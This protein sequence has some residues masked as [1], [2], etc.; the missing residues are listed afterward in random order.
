MQIFEDGLSREN[1]ASFWNQ[2]NTLGNQLVSGQLHQV[3]GG[4]VGRVET[5]FA[6]GLRQHAGQRFKGA[7]FASAVGT[8]EGYQFALGDIET[9]A[10]DGLDTAIL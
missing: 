10:F 5:N 7:G 1:T 3:D 2:S 8:N 9:D 4:L 6:G